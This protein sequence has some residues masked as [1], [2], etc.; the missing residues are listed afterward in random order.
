M[1]NKQVS[2]LKFLLGSLIDNAHNSIL[3]SWISN[4]KNNNH[5]YY[6]Y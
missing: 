6:K 1:S 3:L 5:N 4:D 2:Y